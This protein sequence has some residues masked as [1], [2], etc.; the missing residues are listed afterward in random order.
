LKTASGPILRVRRDAMPRRAIAVAEAH[1]SV[2]RTPD[3]RRS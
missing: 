1:A 3:C 2:P